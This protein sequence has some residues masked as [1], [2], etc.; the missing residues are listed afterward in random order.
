MQAK[1]AADDRWKAYEASSA[2]NFVLPFVPRWIFKLR[3]ML[4]S[5]NLLAKRFGRWQFSVGE[6]L[7]CLMICGQLAWICVAWAAN[8]GGMRYDVG[9]TGELPLLGCVEE[10]RDR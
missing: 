6:L 2:E 5:S 10:L 9:T 4:L 1:R 8:I 3:W 7:A